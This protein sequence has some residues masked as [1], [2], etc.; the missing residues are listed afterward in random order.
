MVFGRTGA[1]PMVC[2]ASLVT[3]SWDGKTELRYWA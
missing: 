3:P 1:A 2:D